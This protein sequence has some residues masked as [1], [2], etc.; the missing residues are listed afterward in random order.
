M[1]E[2]KDIEIKS[3]EIKQQNRA[4]KKP[5]S[6]QNPMPF[7]SKRKRSVSFGLI[8]L[9]I[10]LAFIAGGAGSVVSNHYIL[11]Y[12]STIPFFAQY[13]FFQPDKPVIIEKNERVTIVEESGIIK[14]VQNVS[15]SVVSII[16]ERDL[17]GFFGNIFEQRGGGTGFIITNDGLIATNKHV[18][19]DEKARYTVITSD[20]KSYEAKILAKDPL[21]D[22][23]IIKIEAENLPVVELGSS[24][25]LVVGQKVIAIGNTLGEYQNTVTTGVVSGIGRNITAGVGFFQSENLEDVIQTDAA[26]NPGNSGG[27][28]VNIKGQVIG[29]NTAIDREG[30]LIGFAIPVDS[31]KNVIESVIREGKI[32]RPLI[33]V[34]YLPI[35]PEFA[36]LNNLPV[37]E[38]ALIYT[39]D[40]ELLPVLPDTPAE[41]A[42][43][44]EMDII[45]KINNENIDQDRSL[46]HMLQ[47][48]EPGE[49]ITL[50]V[51]RKGKT[52]ELK[53]TLGEM[54]EN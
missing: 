29:I 43:I 4:L 48:Y 47:K 40:P 2:L 12:L 22:F 1:K 18:V 46:A 49:E 44:Q 45:T 36:S 37:E 50:T 35:T 17:Q 11:P 15:P 54:K 21:N 26:I 5:R 30:Q 8:L 27:P 51:I 53:L 42:G 34:R 3:I 20:G 10:I 31:V 38:G 23:A 39:G 52:L 41:E 6:K 24:S 14:A 13:D 32:V 16:S 19:A 28:L 25:E 9:V 33:G 7:Q